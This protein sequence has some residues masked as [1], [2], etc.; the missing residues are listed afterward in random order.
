MLK[1]LPRSLRETYNRFLQRLEDHEEDKHLVTRMFFWLLSARRPLTEEEMREAIAFTS[2]NH[3]YD[4]AALPTDLR[5]LIRACGNLIVIDPVTN[6][7]Q[8]A[9]Y[10]VEQYLLEEQASGTS[11]FHGTLSYAENEVGL[12]CL[13]YLSFSDFERQ[14]TVRKDNGITEK[15]AAIE[16][17]ML[18]HSGP[19]NLTHGLA[20][21]VAQFRRNGSSSIEVD[22]ARLLP[23]VSNTPSKPSITKYALLSYIIENWLHHTAS[24]IFKPD[25]IPTWVNAQVYEFLLD[26]VVFGQKLPFD[27]FPWGNWDTVPREYLC[28][29]YVE[30]A[31]MLNHISLMRK[32]LDTDT[33]EYLLSAG[34]RQGQINEIHGSLYGLD[35]WLERL[36]ISQ[37]HQEIV[38]QTLETYDESKTQAITDDEWTQRLFANFV[39]ASR[40][41]ETDAI[42]MLLKS[43]R[44]QTPNIHYHILIEATLSQ[45][46]HLGAVL[47][48][49]GTRDRWWN[50]FE[51]EKSSVRVLID[52]LDCNLVELATLLNFQPFLATFQSK[53]K[54][55]ST[56]FT[57]SVFASDALAHAVQERNT[58]RVSG[59][60]NV[61]CQRPAELDTVIA[62][63]IYL[64]SDETHQINS[65][66]IN[67]ILNYYSGDWN[68]RHWIWSTDIPPL[69][70]CIDILLSVDSGPIDVK[71]ATAILKITI[72]D[73]QTLKPMSK[74][75]KNKNTGQRHIMR[76]KKLTD[77][78][79]GS[80]M[81]ND[82][83]VEFTVEGHVA[84]LFNLDSRRVYISILH[85]AVFNCEFE[86]AELLL[87]NGA[88]LQ[89]E[90]GRISPIHYAIVTGK[91]EMLKFGLNHIPP[92]SSSGQLEP[93]N[94][95]DFEM[96]DFLSKNWPMHAAESF[97]A[98]ML[99][100]MQWKDGQKPHF[101]NSEESTERDCS[102]QGEIAEI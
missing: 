102:V 18:S 98:A 71:D 63:K 97:D 7:I 55:V 3:E 64:Q 31:L 82:A 1:K 61:L 30:T 42:E 91:L 84:A 95:S 77:G 6:I 8:F 13:I 28:Q 62:M 70:T 32:I 2:D 29:M 59:I 27:I 85:F 74:E 83:Y 92:S 26:K 4:V 12:V 10:T 78:R 39:H 54:T 60:L 96:S 22:Y 69:M 101:D 93:G 25:Y 5:R 73:H 66:A 90:I 43:N 15:F 23:T 47:C 44:F 40:Q 33:R 67:Y 11:V 72:L 80:F 16:K 52:N 24:Y 48:A 99:L 68:F 87:G 89:K 50:R 88:I 51:M 35:K 86:I 38:Q 49:L 76:A 75:E 14:I 45:N 37:S 9:H 58:K 94:L 19:A 34:S 56:E 57:D 53:L 41:R 21:V 36:R 46:T 65:S 17:A 20:K 100:V 81:T 79:C